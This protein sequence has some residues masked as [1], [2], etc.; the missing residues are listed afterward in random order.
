MNY[1]SHIFLSGNNN[2]I[3]L[4]NFVGDSFKGNNFRIQYPQLAGGIILH[5][6]IDRFTDSHP[7]VKESKSIFQPLCSR[8]SAI[9]TDIIYDHFLSVNWSKYSEIDLQTFV[10]RFY[11]ILKSNF[12]KLPK[13]ATKFM[14]M[15]IARNRLG[16]YGDLNE[17]ERVFLFMSKY[18]ILPN[19]SKE[20]IL[21]LIS[22]YQTLNEQFNSFFPEIIEFVNG[23]DT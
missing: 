16:T 18:T 3:K 5:R 15:M 21:L 6:E 20:I 4:G 10:K 8:Y 13:R 22:E 23:Q 9:V 12:D 19:F 7:I 11:V 1:L 17:L 14:P 2:F